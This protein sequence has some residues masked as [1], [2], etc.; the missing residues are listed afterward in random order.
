[1]IKLIELIL[2]LIQYKV[3]PT[4]A[5]YINTDIKKK[6]VGDEMKT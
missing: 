4:K 3:R 1:M 5:N 2:M 6:R